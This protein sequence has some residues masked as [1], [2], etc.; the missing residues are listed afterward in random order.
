MMILCKTL[1]HNDRV[2]A[3][4]AKIGTINN[5]TTVTDNV[6]DVVVAPIFTIVST[7]SNIVFEVL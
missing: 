4:P 7:D 6:T 2:Q 1:L 3:T 5:P